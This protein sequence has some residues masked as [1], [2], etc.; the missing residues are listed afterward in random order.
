MKKIIFVAVL[1]SLVCGCGNDINSQLKACY[2]QVEK[3]DL[4]EAERICGKV[5][6]KDKTG[7]AE[8]M[9]ASLWSRGEMDEELKQRLLEI[10]ERNT[11]AK[12]AKA[13]SFLNS[14]DENMKQEGIK[15]GK[16]V[17]N[18]K[19]LVQLKEQL[20]YMDKDFAQAINKLI[21]DGKTELTI[22]LIFLDD[23]KQSA[24]GVKYLKEL[25]QENIPFPTYFLGL[26]F[27]AG[28]VVEQDYNESFNY[29][30]KS[31]K[32]GIQ[33]AQVM[34]GIMYFMGHG[35]EEDNIK[36]YE[37][38]TEAY[39]H[40][41]ILAKLIL[42]YDDFKQYT[43]K[44]SAIKMLASK[45]GTYQNGIDYINW[46]RGDEGKKFV[47]ETSMTPEEI[48]KNMLHFL[49]LSNFGIDFAVSF[50]SSYLMSIGAVKESVEIFDN[51][52]HKY[53]KTKNQ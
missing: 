4:K 31:V 41:N 42:E 11:L 38:W 17:F 15:I 45:D 30:K 6:P 1:L 5:M 40:G 51:L 27:Y 10:S 43:A 21:N 19:E 39:K 14:E 3:N 25:E 33:D 26:L 24:D 22:S 46:I 47:Y 16:E 32:L 49:N 9:L 52:H 28:K 13:V 50:T 8:F 53:D 29:F 36:A 23:Q 34:L 44:M 12:L 20:K 37:Y 48:D 7:I 18:S 2:A 35:V